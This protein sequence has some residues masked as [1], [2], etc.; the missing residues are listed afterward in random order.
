MDDDVVG[1]AARQ[2]FEDA[3]ELLGRVVEEGWL[4]ACAVIGF[5]PA[6]A[7]GDDVV[8]YSNDHRKD[9]TTCFHFLRQQMNKRE[10]S[11]NS[12]LADFIAPADTGVADYIGGFAVT[13]GLG[14]E[15]HLETFRSNHDDYN[16]ILLKSLADRLA[17]AFAERMH[18]QVRKEFWGYAE[19]ESF[20]NAEL[21]AES[22]RGNKAGARLSCLPG[23]FRED[24][25]IRITLGN[26]EHRNRIDGKLCHAAD[27]SRVGF[28]SLASR[29]QIFWHRANRQRPGYR[30]CSAPTGRHRDRGTVARPQPGIH[31]LEIHS[32]ARLRWRGGRKPRD[33][34]FLPFRTKTSPGARSA[35][36]IGSGLAETRRQTEIIPRPTQLQPQAIPSFDG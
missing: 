9:V 34:P 23:P 16:D 8:V 24:N 22:Y 18:E 14:I 36:M 11:A 7:V 27:R 4:Q 6:N 19:G 32:S 13:A 35:G 15:K 3:Q 31:P 20:T 29:C 26:A 17:E 21:I 25:P 28:L 5:F 2:L 33:I 10:G 1:E 30:L 12:C